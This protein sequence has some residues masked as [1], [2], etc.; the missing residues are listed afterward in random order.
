[1]KRLNSVLTWTCML[2][3]LLVQFSCNKSNETLPS[4]FGTSTDDNDAPLVASLPLNWTAELYAETASSIEQNCSLSDINLHNGN[5]VFELRTATES[6]IWK[7]NA[8]NG[9]ILWK[10]KDE[11][12]TGGFQNHSLQGDVLYFTDEGGKAYKLDLNSGQKLWEVELELQPGEWAVFDGDDIYLPEQYEANGHRLTGIQRI[13][14]PLREKAVIFRAPDRDNSSEEYIG[15]PALTDC[16]G[17]SVLIFTRHYK[18]EGRKLSFARIIAWDVPLQRSMWFLPVQQH[19]G[20]RTPHSSDIYVEGGNV[21]FADAKFLY[22]I[23]LANGNCSWRS[24]VSIA[25]SQPIQM[26]FG[27]T[28]L[29]YYNGAGWLASL[30]R[31]TGKKNWSKSVAYKEAA[32]CLSLVGEHVVLGHSELDCYSTANGRRLTR[33]CTADLYP[34]Y[35][36]REGA[37]LRAGFLAHAEEDQQLVVAAE[38]HLICL[39]SSSQ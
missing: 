15:R 35:S 7:V 18:K 19:P 8:Q 9:D 28:D 21:F 3:G 24:P 13:R 20:Q 6:G 1:M 33:Y 29:I 23:Q 38:R 4:S 31:K 5:P 10:W 36:D 34:A 26:A 2:L 14:M 12:S 22:N 17:N 32:T 25:P 27:P 11:A 37:S 16:D 39:G 30:Q